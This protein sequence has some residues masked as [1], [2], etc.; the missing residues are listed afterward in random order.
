MVISKMSCEERMKSW[1]HIKSANESSLG[2]LAIGRLGSS[3]FAICVLVGRSPVSSNNSRISWLGEGKKSSKLSSRK[4]CVADGG[5]FGCK[6]DWGW[7]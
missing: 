4:Y 3:S 7:R 5:I 1:V 6:A 2:S